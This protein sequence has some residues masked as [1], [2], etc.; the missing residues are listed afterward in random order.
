MLS[1][2][3]LPFVAIRTVSHYIKVKHGSY[4]W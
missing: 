2:A 3:F 4:V 1:K